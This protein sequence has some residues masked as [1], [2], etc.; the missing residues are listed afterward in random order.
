ML[1]RLGRD[2]IKLQSTPIF[3]L[4]PNLQRRSI[5]KLHVGRPNRRRR[6]GSQSS[7]ALLS[8]SNGE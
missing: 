8:P 7:S 3:K 5:A 6:I 4:L 2:R 1:N